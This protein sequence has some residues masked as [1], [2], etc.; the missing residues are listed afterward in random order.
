[1]QR[2][3]SYIDCLVYA[4]VIVIMARDPQSTQEALKLL[5]MALGAGSLLLDP[6]KNK[7]THN[8]ALTLVGKHDFLQTREAIKQSLLQG[9][10]G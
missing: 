9:K 6:E 3:G 2:C 5:E 10:V 4:D 7:W 8:L 1:M